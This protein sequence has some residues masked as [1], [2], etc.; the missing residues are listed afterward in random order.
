M[1]QILLTSVV[2]SYVKNMKDIVGM[3]LPKRL[4]AKHTPSW[5]D[6]C[7]KCCCGRDVVVTMPE[8]KSPKKQNQRNKKLQKMKNV[9]SSSD[10]SKDNIKKTHSNNSI[11]KN[12]DREKFGVKIPTPKGLEKYDSVSVSRT[13]DAVQKMLMQ[14]IRPAVMFYTSNLPYVS[15]DTRGGTNTYN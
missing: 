12:R 10:G 4:R 14:Y 5:L 11:K 3:V 15:T 1:G 6:C 8:T 2:W 9:S 13:G 7:S